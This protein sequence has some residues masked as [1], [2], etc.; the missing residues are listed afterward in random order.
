MT[1][2]MIK[3]AIDRLDGEGAIGW[4]YA[5]DYTSPPLIRAFLHHDLIGESFADVH[6]PDL[7][8]VGFGDGRC[9]FD[10][11]FNRPIDPGYLSFITVKPQD[12]DLLLPV[13]VATAAYLDLVN[14]VLTGFAGSGRNRSVLGGLWTDRTDA[15]QLLA[16]RIAVGAC[17][18][19]LQSV[20][21]ELILNGH[22]VLH[23]AL[24]PAGVNGKDVANIRFATAPRFLDGEGDGRLK[25][26]LTSVAGLLFREPVVRLLRAAFDDHPVAYRLDSLGGDNRFAQISALGDLPSPGECM[27]VYVGNP[28]APIR[29]DILRNS[30][31][32]PE[33]GPSGRSR[34]TLGGADELSH[35]ASEAGLS[36]ESIE[37]DAQD[38]AIVGPGLIHRVVASREAPAL[39]AVVAP[40]RVTPQRFLSGEGTW[41][42]SGHVSGARIRI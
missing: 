5:A 10:I 34:W 25:T 18:A 9:G 15:P 20:M 40:R 21:Q 28:T 26:A 14:A 8:T 7:E 42:E 22:V 13:P 4:L 11:R 1:A 12:V 16:G 3:G 35:F 27:A 38:V 36:I 33:F 39:R 24:S 17:A 31:E 30:H 23:N 29:I 2:V 19:E 32:L 41:T 37:L 6:R